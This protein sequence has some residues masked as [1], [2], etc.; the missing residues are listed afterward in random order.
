MEIKEIANKF[1]NGEGNLQT[2]SSKY[3]VPYVEIS[4]YL[5]SLGYIIKTGY[6]L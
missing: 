1:L 4:A 6:K 3:H 5:K 2:L